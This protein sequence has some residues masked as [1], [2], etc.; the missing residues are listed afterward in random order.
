MVIS[1]AVYI[2]IIIM[3]T[4]NGPMYHVPMAIHYIVTTS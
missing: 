1:L 2:Y 3:I 4:V